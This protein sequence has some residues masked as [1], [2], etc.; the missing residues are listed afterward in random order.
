MAM[1]KYSHA[2]GLETRATGE[3]SHAE[4]KDSVASGKSSHAEGAGTTASG[5]RS[6]AE[7]FDT[8]AS[9]LQ[10]HAEGYNTKAPSNNSHAE[11]YESQASGNAAHAEGHNTMATGKD[12]H[13]EGTREPWTHTVRK[14]FTDS[15]KSAATESK[16]YQT[17]NFSSAEE[18]YEVGMKLISLNGEDVSDQDITI[19]AVY[20]N[21]SKWFSLS[22]KLGIGNK[23]TA[24][25]E[26]EYDET[27]TEYPDVGAKAE[28]SHVEGISTNATNKGEHAGGRYNLSNYGTVFS[29]GIGTAENDRKNAVEV[30]GNGNLYV[31]G[32][33]GYNGKNAEAPGVLTLQQVLNAIMDIKNS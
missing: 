9:G 14:T 30:M 24:T 19:T 31:I 15:I 25:V 22:S 1:G 13:A 28:G 10:S 5:E 21:G 23:K 7:G 8:T 2:E 6:H 17:L 11:G 32:I 20:S 27:V 12:A 3:R 26:F 33:G 29:I 16:L 18:R 4:G